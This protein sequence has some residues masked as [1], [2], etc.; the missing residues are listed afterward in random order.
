MTLVETRES[1]YALLKEF[2]MSMQICGLYRRIEEGVL[3]KWKKKLLHKM[4]SDENC[5]DWP[6]LRFRQLAFACFIIPTQGR[7]QGRSQS[8][9]QGLSVRRSVWYFSQKQTSTTKKV[10]D[11]DR[12]SL[13]LKKNQNPSAHH[14]LSQRERMNTLDVDKTLLRGVN[15][16]IRTLFSSAKS[17]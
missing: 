9:D 15:K 16:N 11:F 12:S 3:Q 1:N 4:R 7:S 6:L 14:K 5:E 17:V 10:N 2:T 13:R 8:R